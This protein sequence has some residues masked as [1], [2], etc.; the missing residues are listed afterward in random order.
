MIKISEHFKDQNNDDLDDA[1]Y[2]YELNNEYKLLK[3]QLNDSFTKFVNA[4]IK[5]INLVNEIFT[6]L[7]D[8]Q[9]ILLISKTNA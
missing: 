4:E 2:I 3:E 6:L 9:K 7:N 8:E 5:N 1:K